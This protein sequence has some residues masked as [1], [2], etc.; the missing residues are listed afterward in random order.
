[1]SSSFN[2]PWE[3]R[4][5]LTYLHYK[6]S[7]CSAYIFQFPVGMSNRSYLIIARKAAILTVQLSI[8][9]GNVEQVL[10]KAAVFP[11]PAEHASFNSPW[12]CRIGLTTCDPRIRSKTTYNF[13]FPV[14][15]SNRSYDKIYVGTLDIDHH[16]F[17][18]PVG[19]SNRS[20]WGLVQCAMLSSHCFPFNSPWEC[21]IGLTMKIGEIIQNDLHILSIPRGNV[22]Q[23][24]HCMYGAGEC[25][26]LLPFNSPWECRIGLTKAKCQGEIKLSAHLSIPR[27]NVEQVLL[28]EKERQ[29]KEH[30]ERSFNSPWECRIGLT[31]YWDAE[32]YRQF[33]FQFPVGMSNRSYKPELGEPVSLNSLSFQF[34]VGM[35]NRSY[36][37]SNQQFQTLFLAFNS[38]WE[39]R[40]GLTRICTHTMIACME[41]AFNSPWECRIGLT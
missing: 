35:S 22:E 4:I 18:F 33:L 16:I 10:P 21:R 30:Y 15:M 26:E 28:D 2:S 34:P 27:G 8:P 12:E 6:R 13:Q 14:G 3:C 31:H 5:G 17:Q 23:V 39:C 11:M 29:T 38:P 24:L 20:Y 1:M 40:I 9:R 7:Q 25:P 19:M 41:Q 37:I 32:N 36:L